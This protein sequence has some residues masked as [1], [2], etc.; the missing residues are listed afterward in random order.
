MCIQVVDHGC[1]A[2]KMHV[3]WK[4]ALLLSLSLALV[5]GY[6]FVAPLF[7]PVGG[8]TDVYHAGPISPDGRLKAA[9]HERD[10]GATT[11]F[12]TEVLITEVNR[13]FEDSADVAAVIDGPPPRLEWEGSDLRVFKGDAPL[14]RGAST[15]RGATVSY[16]SAD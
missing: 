6:V 9:V 3:R 14:V 1:C 4:L 12:D 8:C 11:G 16:W 13:R 5:L 10:C 2:L 15:A 7:M